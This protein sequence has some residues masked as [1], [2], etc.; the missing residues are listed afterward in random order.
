MHIFNRTK[1]SSVRQRESW[2]FPFPSY[3]EF[4]API[5][6]ASNRFDGEPQS[7]TFPTGASEQNTDVDITQSGIEPKIPPGSRLLFKMNI[8]DAVVDDGDLGFRIAKLSNN[9]VF[10]EFGIRNDSASSLLAQ[11]L[12]FKLEDLVVL[13]IGKTKRLFPAGFERF[14]PFQPN[15]MHTIAR[16]VTVAGFNAFETE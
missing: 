6:Q 16:P 2:L 11:Q 3:Q 13:A 12:L 1:E 15:S 5:L 8:G 10:N 14:S 4:N 9:F 7:F